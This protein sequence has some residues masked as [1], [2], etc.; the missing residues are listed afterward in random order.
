MRSDPICEWAVLILVLVL[1]LVLEFF[2]L[3]RFADHH[4]RRGGR[5]EARNQFRKDRSNPQQ[6]LFAIV[7]LF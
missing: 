7:D 2:F 4:G 1:V 5:I 3:S 6:K